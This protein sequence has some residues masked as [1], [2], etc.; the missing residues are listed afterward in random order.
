MAEQNISRKEFE[1]Y[2]DKIQYQI[3]EIKDK[4]E[5]NQNQINNIKK[6]IK[7]KSI[8]INDK[9]NKM[10]KLLEKK[11]DSK[12][13]IEKNKSDNNNK[14]KKKSKSEKNDI[15]K[16]K[17]VKTKNNN[18]EKIRYIE[19]EDQDD[20]ILY[21]YSLSKIYNNKTIYYYCI[22]THCLGRLKVLLN[23]DINLKNY[24]DLKINSY[25]LTAKHSLKIDEHNYFINKTVKEDIKNKPITYIKKKM[26]SYIYLYHAIKEEG[27]KNK[28]RDSNGKILYNFIYNKY[29]DININLN[30]INKDKLFKKEIN[31][32]KKSNNIQGNDEINYKTIISLKTI[33]SKVNTYINYYYNKNKNLKDQ[34]LSIEYNN[35]KIT[36][37][38][39]VS[40]KKKNKEC[41]KN[42]FYFISEEMKINLGNKNDIEQ[43]FM[44]ATHYA[45]P[46]KNNDFKLILIIGYNNKEN[47]TCLGAIILIQNEN[48]ETFCKIFSYLYTNYNFDPQI[49]NIDCN[50]A[51]IISIKKNFINAKIVI[52]F[53]H[54]VKRLIQHI[55]QIRSKNKELKNKAKNLLNNIKLM[56]FIKRNEVHNYFKKIKYIFKND[57]PKFIKYFEY[58]F[59][60]KYPMKD[61]DWNYDVERN[62]FIDINHYFLQIIYAR[63]QIVLSI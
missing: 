63:A 4:N 42:I 53:Y 36:E 3:Q 8:E 25:T 35:K 38:E 49:I 7:N 29:G 52:C 9:L 24:I 54:I 46:R 56:L 48:V 62:N 23:E 6:T 41:N 10:I 43:W 60:K 28:L 21:K 18:I 2:I 31:N 1:N 13:E 22:D 37:F 26:N 44:D 30:N 27:I 19:I 40:F 39:T 61:L 20:P 12:E 57:F 51:E 55:P 15:K 14:E 33:C 50:N 58:Y 45:I 32:Y 17:E 5:E 34:L 11:E 16:I 47:K 59:F